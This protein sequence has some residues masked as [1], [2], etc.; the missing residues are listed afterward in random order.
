MSGAE[1][2]MGLVGRIRQMRRLPP[3]MTS[4]TAAAPDPVRLEAL[5]RRLEQLENMVQ[6]LQDAIYRESRRQHDRIADLEAQID[7]AAMATAL[8]KDARERG[9]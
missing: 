9:L 7:P 8:S 6:G 3:L 1:R 4:T 5:E 2:D